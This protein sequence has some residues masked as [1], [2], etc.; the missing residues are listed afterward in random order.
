M[1]V[2]RNDRD[3]YSGAALRHTRT[4]TKASSSVLVFGDLVIM[5]SRNASR[6]LTQAG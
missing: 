3:E 2:I 1:V 5:H 6:K 4:S